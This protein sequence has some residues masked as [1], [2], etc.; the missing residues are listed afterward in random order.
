M[1]DL[2]Q[3]ELELDAPPERVWQALIDPAWLSAWLADEVALEP[4]P[5]GEAR[6]RFG[7]GLRDGWI[8]EVTS[9]EESR[10]GSG[11]LTFW[12]TPH[13]EP[14]SRVELELLPTAGG[15]SRVRV[16]ET[17]PLE[18]LDLIGIPL[19]GSTPRGAGPML[20]AA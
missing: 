1:N 19:P 11:R 5:G 20:V 4:W 14:V 3:R 10:D 17:R 12:W 7:D 9:P 15:G 16:A 13:G 18:V 6:F 2:V 8:E